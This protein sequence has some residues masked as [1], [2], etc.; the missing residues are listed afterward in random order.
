LKIILRKEFESPTVS[1]LQ[2]RTLTVSA[3]S[4]S[5]LDY[6]GA[7]AKRRSEFESPAGTYIHKNELFE[8]QRR[9]RRKT[10]AS[11]S[12]HFKKSKCSDNGDSETILGVFGD[13]GS[14][15]K[16]PRCRD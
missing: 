15:T 2:I 10:K 11:M 8:V 12:L 14:S 7:I 1:G 13:F 16:K 9:K 3:T 6:Q 5:A 4:A